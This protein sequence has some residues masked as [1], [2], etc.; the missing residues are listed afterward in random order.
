MLIL[1]LLGEIE[2]VR[3][4]ERLTL[5]PSK[6]TRGLLAYLAV[7]GRRHRRD[8][9]CSMLWEIPNDPR[10]ALRWSLTKL[11]SLVDEPSRK[12]I[13][14]DRETVGFDLEGV[15]IDVL[16]LRQRLRT[17]SNSMTVGQLAE[18]AAIF[19]GEFLEGLDLASCPE[20]Q[21]WCLAERQDL[22]ALHARLLRGLASQLATR[23]EQAL[24]H[25]RTLVTLDPFD[26]AARAMLVRLLAKTGRREE[27]EQ[28]Y[29]LSQRTLAEIGA[30]TSGELERV[31]QELRNLAQAPR[32]ADSVA[33]SALTPAPPIA[34]PAEVRFAHSVGR[35]AE[36]PPSSDAPAA[37]ATAPAAE[38]KQ[39]TVL[40]A[41][42]GH[43][44]DPAA[45]NDPEAMM[46]A[47]DP[48][49][50]A[51]KDAVHRHEG[52]VSG[53]QPDG[54]TALFGAPI[55]HEDH[56][57][58]A[59]RAAMAMQA[60]VRDRRDESPGLSIG[61]HS[62]EVVVRAAGNGASTRF[63]AVGP[64]VTL[65]AQVGLLAEPGAIVLTRETARRAEGFVQVQPLG[66]TSSA[67]GDWQQ[68]LLLL[69]GATARTRWEV[70]A[71]QGLTPFV[72]RD[73]EMEALSRAM[74]RVEAGHGEVVA[75]VADPGI[76]KSRLLHEFVRSTVPSGW[77]VLETSAASHDAK[78]TYRPVSEMLRA[79]FGVEERDVKPEI[80]RKARA[81]IESLFPELRP[82]LPALMSLLDLPVADGEW[83]N[84][85]PAQRRRRTLDAV[86][87]VLAHESRRKPL[88]LLFE[89]LHWI[90]G[91]T[92]AVLDTLVDSLGALRLL[93]LVTHRPEY[94][95]GWT[96]KS[97]F[98]QLR[99][100]PLATDMAERLLESL[101]GND[102]SLEGL[103][104]ELVARTEGTPL[105]AEE[106]V[107]VLV[108]AGA[109]SGRPG[110]YRVGRP[111]ATF[112]IP[113]T[114]HAVI[115]ARIDRLRPE[116][117]NL[118]QVASI[119]G[120]DVPLALL[121]QVAGLPED[122]LDDALAG[123]QAAEFL[124]ETRLLPDVEYSFKHA[125]TH[126][127]AYGSVLR[128]RR[129]TIHVEIVGTIEKLTG[130]RIDEQVE[131]LAHHAVKGRLWE[132]ALHYLYR[133]ATKAIQRSA[134]RQAMEFLGQGLELIPKLPETRARQQ[135]ELDYQ[136]AVG[137]TMMAAKGWGA[138]EVSDA[139]VRAR[140]LAEQLGDSRELFVVLRG[141]GQFHMV[142]GEV[143]IARRLGER[144][145][146]LAEGSDDPALAI[147]THHLFWSNSVFMGDYVNAD[148]HAER[149][150]ALYDRE[151]DHRLTY[152]YSGH[153]PGV[154]CRCMS[155]LVLWQR[156]DTERALARCREALELAT[157]VSHPLT[158][159][160]AHWGLS[161]AH[162]FRREPAEAQRA[163]EQEIAICE[164]YLLPLLLSQGQFQLGWALAAQGALDEGIALMQ[165]G[166]AAISATGAE[167]G[168]PYFSALY[169]EALAQTGRP[170]DGL[171]EI[172]RA[173]HIV[174][175]NRAC[176]QLPEIL[177]LK[178]ELLKLLPN[179]DVD[180]VITCF[181]DAMATARMQGTP[182]LELRAAT[183][184]ARFLFHR[185]NRTEARRLL[186][187]LCRRSDGMPESIELDEARLLLAQ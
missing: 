80:E 3:G 165:K 23:P 167:M 133:A 66:T 19:R 184:L 49:L 181:R 88:A 135:T 58:R 82:A 85:S 33:G 15:E 31:R 117:K 187:E 98:S 60:A 62:G 65:A 153:D 162:M 13:L 14:A 47:L 57:V 25:V 108:E 111:L 183:S 81:R 7:T 172:E 134:H 92:Q 72:G 148:H 96:G 97:Y 5:P 54:L 50:E 163:A 51:M 32:S 154:C 125:L 107:R 104:R 147:E 144:C 166:L 170:Q 90:D 179:Y 86:K 100:L 112:E 123:L 139:Y 61:L 169:A 6:R 59:C 156:G 76:G 1:R 99:L 174:E 21:A 27:A 132:K 150:I 79:W 28:Q 9:L 55:A 37:A 35:I 141:Q 168:R 175:T 45:N 8:R 84:F 106:T 18:A 52:I 11:R 68:D 157:E 115:A 146:A 109:L 158:T 137:V 22:K 105:F 126:E 39:I 42:V 48:A 71:A 70:R 36:S 151:R 46:Q 69:R 152:I 101:I 182:L 155:G 138:Q 178:G 10:G 20:F 103:R 161:Y 93:L 114:I 120:R 43:P 128:E 118:L 64:V 94:R 34:V 41:V 73:A 145:V 30:P 119:I 110:H 129:R 91:E 2:V 4:D 89:D 77:G 173:L 143:Q 17:G 177:R 160:L 116:S 180:A 44:H 131:R 102:R 127:V 29:E 95:H 140:T 56:A 176:F 74:R 121:M 78:A 186:S 171:A 87:S 75:V 63:E 24:P 122:T 159:A 149:G 136:K 12:R 185:R 26:E 164:E 16:D 130:D 142:R 83:P 67:A 53:A 124:Y 40:V 113:S 38:R